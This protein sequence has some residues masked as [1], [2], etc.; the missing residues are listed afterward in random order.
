VDGF[1]GWIRGRVLWAS[2]LAGSRLQVD[3]YTRH[4]H[5][6]YAWR[7]YQD[8]LALEVGHNEEGGQPRISRTECVID[9]A[10]C[11][12]DLKEYTLMRYLSERTAEG[13]SWSAG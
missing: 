3:R 4:V 5:E 12:Y 2:W 13:C 7:S 11:L 10:D 6:R 9:G 1:L 8:L